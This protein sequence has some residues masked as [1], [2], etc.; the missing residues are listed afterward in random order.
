[1][2]L[3]FLLTALIFLVVLSAIVTFILARATP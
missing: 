2:G 1:V 3:F